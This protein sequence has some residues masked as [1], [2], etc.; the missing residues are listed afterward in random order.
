MSRFD[1]E[2]IMWDWLSKFHARYGVYPSKLWIDT[3]SYIHLMA[4]M[5]EG[6]RKGTPH[7]MGIPV[8]ER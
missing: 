4:F 7:V 6:I 8:Y 5:P 2:A 3:R 1:A